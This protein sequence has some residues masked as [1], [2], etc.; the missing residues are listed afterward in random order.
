MAAGATDISDSVWG[1]DELSQEPDF[2][3]GEVLEFGGP[4]GGGL[5]CESRG[6][7]GWDDFV[8][9]GEGEGRCRIVHGTQ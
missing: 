9:F 5:L 4:H 2:F 8:G 7:G 1:V 3:G 6:D